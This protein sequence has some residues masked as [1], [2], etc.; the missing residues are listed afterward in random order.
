MFEKTKI[1]EICITSF[2]FI[3]CHVI[4]HQKKRGAKENVCKT[5]KCTHRKLMAP[6][7]VKMKL[8][9]SARSFE[10]DKLLS[11]MHTCL[12]LRKKEQI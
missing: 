6:Q 9:K 1:R 4:M 11:R 2:C 8:Y 10:I 5:L 3:L 12:E 7:K